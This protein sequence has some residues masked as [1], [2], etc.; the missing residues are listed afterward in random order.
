MRSN[1]VLQQL[2]EKF[3]KTNI[4]GGAD[5]SGGRKKNGEHVRMGVVVGDCQEGD[6]CKKKSWGR[7]KSRSDRKIAYI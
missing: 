1:A 2:A 3:K 6:H 5:Q 4:T 7:Y